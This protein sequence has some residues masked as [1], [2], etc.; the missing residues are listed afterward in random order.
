MKKPFI[1][2]LDKIIILLLFIMGVFS[3]CQKDEPKP[4][5]G[6]VP[7]Y[8]TPPPDKSVVVA[9]ETNDIP[10]FSEVDL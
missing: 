9:Q 2:L 3:S 1:K 5:Y 8:G 7:L 6:N 4:K 10:L